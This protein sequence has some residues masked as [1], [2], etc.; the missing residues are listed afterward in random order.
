MRTIHMDEPPIQE[1]LQTKRIILPSESARLI[2]RPPQLGGLF[3]LV[4]SKL[5][6]TSLQPRSL[7]GLLA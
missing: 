1:I 7:L 2:L 5:T 4:S 6:T 3:G